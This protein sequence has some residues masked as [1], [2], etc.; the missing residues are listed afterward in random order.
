MNVFLS[1]PTLLENC[2]SYALTSTRTGCGRRIAHSILVSYVFSRNRPLIPA[3]GDVGAR[4]YGSSLTCGRM[5]WS[6]WSSSVAVTE[7]THEKAG[8]VV[9]E[10]GAAGLPLPRRAPGAAACPGCPLVVQPGTGL[11]RRQAPRLGSLGWGE[12]EFTSTASKIQRSR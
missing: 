6:S 8:R 7:V 2:C 11:P 5:S 4:A 9:A 12:R 3:R 10:A 1:F